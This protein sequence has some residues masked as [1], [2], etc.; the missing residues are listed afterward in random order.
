MTNS[1]NISTGVQLDLSSNQRN[2]QNLFEPI[3]L[4]G[5]SHGIVAQSIGGGGGIDRKSVV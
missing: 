3:V 1:G 2:N 4:G 5:D